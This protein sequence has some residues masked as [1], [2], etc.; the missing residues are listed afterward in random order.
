LD[1]SSEKKPSARGW[2]R[3]WP[4][5]TSF[6]LALI[7][8]L[9]VVAAATA[10]SVVFYVGTVGVLSRSSE[11]KYQSI[12]DRL[13]DQYKTGGR[14]RLL[15]DIKHLLDDGVDSE[16]EVYLLADSDGNIL[17]GNVTEWPRGSISFDR[18]SDQRITRAGRRSNSRLLP[19]ALSNGDV[20]IVGRDMSD[21]HKIALL[22]WKA[23]GGSV[24][25]SIAIAIVGAW[26]LR[27]QVDAHLA[28]I[29]RTTRSVVTGDLSSRVPSSPREDEFARL[30][31]D[32]NRMLDQI[33]Q[34]MEGTVHISNIIAHNLRTPLGRIRSGLDQALSAQSNARQFA[35]SANVAITAIDD[36]I[37]MFE[38]LLTIAESES[39]VHRRSFAPVALEPLVEEVVELYAAMAEDEEIV[40]RASVQG[41]PV[42]H[43]DKD[44]IAVAVSNLV[45]NALKYAGRGA[46]VEVSANDR[47]DTV[48][49][50]VADNG[51]GIPPSERPKVTQRFYRMEVSRAQPG[52]GLGLSLVAAIASLHLGALTLEDA[53]PGLLARIDLPKQQPDAVVQNLSGATASQTVT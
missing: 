7:Q 18:F 39:G 40:L 3:F 32:I 2:R 28:A 14:A 49:V 1:T 27:R 17:G 9:V 37:V 8:G 52:S 29:R 25:V 4:V 30:S 21:Q 31:Q 46:A 51:P 38:N 36:L 16:S 26:L 43:G 5:S 33:Q 42:A 11:V 15:D 6:R 45:E 41:R 48:S 50:I 10:G 12:S 13:V 35:T 20:L 19:R 44:L 24:M 22:V 47:G 23:V 53:G 34:L